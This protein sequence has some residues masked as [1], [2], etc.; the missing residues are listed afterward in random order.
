MEK[1]SKNVV[2]LVKKYAIKA[3]A[4]NAL[5]ALI[6]ASVEDR[7]IDVLNHQVKLHLATK[8]A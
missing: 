1:R 7:D 3:P 5:R 4:N 6:L 2:M 8:D